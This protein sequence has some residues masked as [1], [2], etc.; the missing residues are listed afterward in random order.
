M[1][2]FK[3]KLL[4]FCVLWVFLCI[5]RCLK[6]RWTILCPSLWTYDDVALSRQR[7]ELEGTRSEG[8]SLWRVR[9]PVFI[10]HRFEWCFGVM[11]AGVR[12][13]WSHRNIRNMRVL[14][15]SS[16]PQSSSLAYIIH[17]CCFTTCWLTTWFYGSTLNMETAIAEWTCPSLVAEN[18]IVTSTTDGRGTLD[19]TSLIGLKIFLAQAHGTFKYAKLNMLMGPFQLA[20]LSFLYTLLTYI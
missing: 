11:R 12:P 16:L 10:N 3:V 18:I 15:S 6:K 7:I 1:Y 14:V 13:R 2:I 17:F 5:T 19:I 9:C 4:Y 8:C 20:D